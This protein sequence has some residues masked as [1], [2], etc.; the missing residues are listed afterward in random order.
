MLHSEN[1]ISE[2]NDQKEVSSAGNYC[3]R[4]PH[5]AVT[6]DCVIFGFTGKELKILLVERGNEPYLG[7]WALPGGF[8]RMNETIEQTAARELAE[9]TNLT[10]VFLDQFKVY[11]RVDRDPRERVIT[12]AFI[13]LLK[14]DDYKVVAGDD[15]VNAIWFNDKM[16]PPLAFD[17]KEI[18]QEARQYLKEILKL[19]PVAF[20]LLNKVFTIAELQAVYEVIN[21]ANYDRRNFL[22]TALDSEIIKEVP[23]E[24]SH[25]NHRISRLY[26]VNHNF[27]PS[28]A[29]EATTFSDDIF[30]A[31][32]K[33]QVK[34][35]NNYVEAESFEKSAL[36]EE[37]KEEKERK[38]PTKGLFD[39][40]RN[41]SSS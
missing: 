7:Y 3:Y 37:I 29:F 16:L 22:R 12:V 36:K 33:S 20:E 31:D 18:I 41:L 5:A 4:Y 14:P 38:T 15:A 40:L 25:S 26:T 21:S 32:S 23:D 13:A 10:N 17:H 9:E 1:K 39:F 28:H 6:A 30:P 2:P 8:M 27:L 24:N 34:S 35:D 11:S 19:K